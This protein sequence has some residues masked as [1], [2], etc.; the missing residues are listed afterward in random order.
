MASRLDPARH[1]AAAVI[2]FQTPDLLEVAVRTF[3]AAYPTV[4]L[5]IID[6]GSQDESAGV[7]RRLVTELGPPVSMQLLERNVYHGPA[8]HRAMAELVAPYVY[9]FDSDTETRRG[10]FLEAMLAALAADP[11]HYGAGQRVYVN[12]RGF[13]VEEGKGVPVLASAHMLLKRALYHRLPPF[14][15]HG[16]PAL[17]NFEAAA[18]QG[19]RLC[20]FPIEDYVYHRGRGTA[21]R[22][23]YGLGLRGKAEYLLNK[24][25]L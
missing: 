11:L 18:A 21:E 17:H 24:L 7:I 2:N 1:V 14:V 3:H 20:P 10:G 12:R 13:R 6:N 9:V 25:G 23:G 8:M 16:L 5:L 22:Y 19:L 15:H 4:P